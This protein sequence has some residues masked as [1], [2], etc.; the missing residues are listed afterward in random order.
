MGIDYTKLSEKDIQAA[1]VHYL[2]TRKDIVFWRQ[3]TGS[4]IPHV[5]RI[6]AGILAKFRVSRKEIIL[7]SVKRAAGHYKCT[8]ISGISDIIVIQNGL[9]IGLEVKTEKGKQRDEQKKFEKD[10]LK[11]GGQYH[12]VRS[13]NDVIKIIEG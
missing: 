7:A 10:V 2:G 12:L 6:L 8:S 4:M 1:I 5:M 9:F 3:N 13:L 11:A